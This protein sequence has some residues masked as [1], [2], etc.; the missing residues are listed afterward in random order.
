MKKLSLITL[1][2]FLGI[3]WLMASSLALAKEPANGNKIAARA[4]KYVLTFEAL[5][6][7]IKDL[8]PEYQK[9]VSQ[10]PQLKKTI[11]D[12]W[13]QVSLLSQEARAHK[14]DRDKTISEKINEVVNI[15]LA[16]EFIGRYILD[17][18]NVTDK[19]VSAYYAEHK[20]E[21]KDPEMIKARHILVRV[22]VEAKPDDWIAAE[23]RIHEIKKRLEGGE[24]FAA[25][26]KASSE[27]PGSEYKGGDLGFF[28][29]GQM[30]PEFENAAFALKIGEVSEPVKTDFG[31]HI[32]KVE[33]RKEE[34][35]K[36][37]EEVKED[38]QNKLITEKQE[39]AITK[40]LLKLENKYGVTVSP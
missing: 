1:Y 22:P 10:N 34:K 9:M 36:A 35:V 32:I 23:T 18:V 3:A 21:F 20:H 33:D 4:G 14:L 15:V 19:D 37:P 8:P 2:L 25:A 17:K 31:Y 7:K 27:D 24:D 16:Q 5:N 11:I 13:V 6:R 28:P 38:I 26:A 12:R 29:R 39:E 30:V 40:L